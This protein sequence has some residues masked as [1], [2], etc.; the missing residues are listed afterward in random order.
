MVGFQGYGAWRLWDD[1]VL[2]L[3]LRDG[4]F[5]DSMADLLGFWSTS[6]VQMGMSWPTISTNMKL[7]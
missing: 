2:G 4:W 5:G 1:R 6:H 7:F 3:R